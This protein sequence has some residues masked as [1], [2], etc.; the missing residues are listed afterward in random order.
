MS[1]PRQLP[2]ETLALVFCNLSQKELCRCMLVSHLWHGEAQTQLYS[3]ITFDSLQQSFSTR[4]SAVR[5]HKHLL[6]RVAW[7]SHVSGETVVP[8]LLD[9]LLDYRPDEHEAKT[10]GSPPSLSP[11]LAAAN[12]PVFYAPG[13]NCPSLTHLSYTGNSSSWRFFES[14]LC[15]LTSLM[16]LDIHFLQRTGT[17]A[18]VGYRIDI[19]R[20]LDALRCLKHLSIIGWITEYVPPTRIEPNED[21]DSHVEVEREGASTGPKDQYRLESCTFTPCLMGQDGRDASLFFRRLGNLKRIVI[22]PNYSPDG[23]YQMGR[24]YDFVRALKEFCTKLE[25]VETCGII[26]L[27]LFDLPILPYDQLLHLRSLVSGYSLQDE[28][29]LS[30]EQT[31]D[32]F[33]LKRDRMRQRF[34]EQEVGELLEGKGADPIFPQ[35]KRLVLG[36]DHSLSAQDLISLGVQAR[37]LTDLD[38]QTSSDHFRFWEMYDE[39]AEAAIPPDSQSAA[40]LNHSLSP[41]G[42]AFYEQAM[43]EVRRLRNRR[44]FNS[45]DLMLFLQLCPSLVRFSMTK[46][47]ISFED[48]L[49]DKA[50]IRPWA[51]EGTLESLT[52]GFDIPTNQYESH[53]LVWDHL[54]RFKKLRSLTFAHSSSPSIPGRCGLIPSFDYGVKALFAGRGVGGMS[55]TLEEIGCLS[56][57]WKVDD[58]KEMVLWFARSFP[59]LGVLGL[60]FHE[61]YVKGKKQARYTGFLK[62]EGVK[63]CSIPRIFFQ[64]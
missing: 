1:P 16:S 12:S 48:L 31:I 25:S 42:F 22:M 59:K 51:C 41:N 29:G 44:A 54:G 35:L 13:P 57:W 9:I 8:E 62:D 7:R 64:P 58:R 60:K 24:P 23:V 52:I 49:D 38:I 55:E 27:W 56:S 63:N 19:G 18:Q 50:A 14:V 46:H 26:P 11:P 47:S 5:P 3:N 21:H 33:E 36:R 2:A 6:R 34:H 53:K 61:A 15:S 4:I 45:R 37:F 32:A 39:D 28:S 10:T 30:E 20:I 17:R 40:Q 43:F